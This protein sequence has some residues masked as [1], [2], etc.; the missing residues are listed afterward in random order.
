VK[1]SGKRT[2]VFDWRVP[3]IA[4]DR[5]GTIR[6]DLFWQPGSSSSAPTGAIV[7]FAIFFA[8]T[9]TWMAVVTRRRRNKRQ[10]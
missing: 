10:L 9:A 5:S 4:G 8:V 7:A 6:G 1:D 2:K 3:I